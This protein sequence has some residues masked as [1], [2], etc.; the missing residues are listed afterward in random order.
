[1]GKTHNNSFATQSLT[2]IKETKDTNLLPLFRLSLIVR[3]GEELVESGAETEARRTHHLLT[4]HTNTA[5]TK[6]VGV[7]L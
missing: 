3:S 2:A 7:Y 1:M 5:A 6:T 4:F